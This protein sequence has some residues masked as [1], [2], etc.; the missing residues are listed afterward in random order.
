V[1]FGEGEGKCG[2]RKT[3]TLKLEHA[4]LSPAEASTPFPEDLQKE[5]DEQEA[6]DSQAWE[7]PINWSP[8]TW[9]LA[10]S[11]EVEQGLRRRCGK[12]VTKGLSSSRKGGTTAEGLVK[13]SLFL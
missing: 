1:E 8:E 4:D 11:W 10:T 5:K 7:E 2:E 3:K 9:N 12:A 6:G 13:Q